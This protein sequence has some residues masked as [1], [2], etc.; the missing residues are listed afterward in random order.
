MYVRKG[1]STSDE[2]VTSLIKDTDVT[3]VGENGEWYKIKYK[4]FEGYIYK[5]L[6]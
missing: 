3:V 4:E 1:P 2:I 6:L 5:N